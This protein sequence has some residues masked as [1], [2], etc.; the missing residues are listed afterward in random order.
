[1][2]GKHF[3][4][5]L[6]QTC[7]VCTKVFAH[8]CIFIR[9]F[10]PRNMQ[11]PF[12]TNFELSFRYGKRAIE[13]QNN[14]RTDSKT[15][16]YV[17]R[18]LD[19][20]PEWQPAKHSAF[21]VCLASPSVLFTFAAVLAALSYLCCWSSLCALLALPVRSWAGGATACSYI[22][23]TRAAR[24]RALLNGHALLHSYEKKNQRIFF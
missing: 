16:P 20:S 17:S 11:N 6:T 13:G 10:N 18:D 7:M 5:P 4:W 3:R 24:G 12:P 21:P 19:P 9:S 23:L 8:I 22:W 1:M 14:H 2:L 15:L